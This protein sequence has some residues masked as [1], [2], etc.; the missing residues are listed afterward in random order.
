VLAYVSQGRLFFR[1]TL[2]GRELPAAAETDITAF[3]FSPEGVWLATAHDQG[4]IRVREQTTNQEILRFDAAPAR[5]HQL[6]WTKDGKRLISGND[7]QTALVWDLSSPERPRSA[8]PVSEEQLEQAWSALGTQDAGRA[9]RAIWTLVRA[10]DAGVTL[11]E[12][13]LRPVASDDKAE[14]IRRLIAD[15]DHEKFATRETACRELAQFGAEAEP[16][17]M[18][19][20]ASMPSPEVRG[21]IDTLLKRIAGPEK[22]PTAAQVQVR[23]ALVALER[24]GSPRS[25]KLLEGLASGATDVWQTTAAQQ[26]LDRLGLPR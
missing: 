7:D 26:A 21:R 23:R 8:K 13:R 25:R 10:G 1:Q 3:A 2:T 22:K 12:K 18:K 6:I 24:I 4:S 16:A 20:L 9:Y 19:A 15:L 11:L 5:V 14:H 17:L